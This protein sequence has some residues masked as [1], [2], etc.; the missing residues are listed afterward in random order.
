MRNPL[1]RGGG[2]S[3]ALAVLFLAAV[4]ALVLRGS[5]PAPVLGTY[6]VASA[7][8]FGAYAFDK[9]AARDVRRRVPENA[10]HL[11]GLLGGWPGALVAQHLFH[12]K[13]R[14]LGFQVVVWGMVA[15]HGAALGWWVLRRGPG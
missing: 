11:V 8:A 4:G 5:L 13:T 6:L 1:Q 7:V 2:A 14:K 12:H 10:L 3:V 9:A 15:L